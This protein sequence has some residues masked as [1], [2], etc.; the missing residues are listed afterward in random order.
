MA[1]VPL[2]PHVFKSVTLA[3][4]EGFFFSWGQ[5]SHTEVAPSQVGQS[6]PSD[7]G[8]ELHKGDEDD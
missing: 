1:N 2:N 3:R 4:P 8:R 5:G 7:P 6:H